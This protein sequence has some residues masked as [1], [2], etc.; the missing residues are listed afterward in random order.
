MSYICKNA[1]RLPPKI[2]ED[3]A[4][5]IAKAMRNTP[6]ATKPRA[7]LDERMPTA[8]QQ[9]AAKK[10]YA[11]LRRMPADWITIN[12]FAKMLGVDRHEIKTPIERLHDEGAVESKS[13]GRNRYW[14]PSK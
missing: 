14:R 12:D 10:R 13:V 5:I 11:L 3:Y 8:V 9:N 2:A 4:H 1:F 6:P 7:W